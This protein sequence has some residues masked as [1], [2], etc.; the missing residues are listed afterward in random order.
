MKNLI[1]PETLAFF[2]QSPTPLK[3]IVA[4]LDSNSTITTASLCKA[5]GIS[6]RKIHDYKYLNK[7]NKL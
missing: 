5:T 3:E 6:P 7:K 4:F 2:Q 1:S